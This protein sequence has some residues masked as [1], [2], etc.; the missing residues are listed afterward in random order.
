MASW[1]LDAGLKAYIVAC[2]DTGT[3][4]GSYNPQS[5]S[6]VRNRRAQGPETLKPK[7]MKLFLSGEGCCK[8]RY[9]K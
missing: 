2:N 3:R 5:S 9:T 8:A 4:R 1:G 7:P 6:D